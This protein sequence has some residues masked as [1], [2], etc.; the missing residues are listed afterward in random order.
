M[1]RQTHVLLYTDD[2]GQGG[3]SV[4]SNAIAC[5]LAAAAYN[6]TL[7]QTRSDSPLVDQQRQAGVQHCWLD[8][9]TREEF[10]RTVTDL[11]IPARIFSLTKPDLVLFA[12]CA[13]VSHIAAK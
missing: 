10:S 5:G 4:Y 7:V 13:P 2:P 9:D 8:F 3:V 12:N 6:V 11:E 1:K